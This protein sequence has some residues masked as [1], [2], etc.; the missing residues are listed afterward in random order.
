MKK[1]QKTKKRRRR[2]LFI[3]AAL[4]IAAGVIINKAGYTEVSDFFSSFANSFAAH[5][6]PKTLF[7][8]ED[9][10]DWRLILVNYQ[11]PVPEGFETEL[12]SIRNNQEVDARIYPDLQEMFDDA[13]AEGVMPLVYSSYRTTQ[14]QQQLYDDEIATYRAQG[15]SYEEAEKIAKTWVAVRGASE[16]QIGL[17]VDITSDN[18]ETQ[19]PSVVWQWLK[20]NSYKYGFILRYPEDKTEITGISFE[21]WHYRYVGKAAAKEIYESGVCLEEYLNKA[22]S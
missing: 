11:N 7:K 18:Q 20:E 1:C 5:E 17:A 8:A 13:R 21:P 22:N 14:K 9:E 2:F 12:I 4:I 3:T 10:E 15:Y 19:D 6:N 16:H